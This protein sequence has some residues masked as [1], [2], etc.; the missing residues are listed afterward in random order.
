MQTKIPSPSFYQDPLAECLRTVLAFYSIHVDIEGVLT[1]IPRNAGPMKPDDILEVARK[2]SL[3]GESLAD[4]GQNWDELDIPAI[5]FLKDGSCCVVFPQKTHPGKVYDPTTGFKVSSWAEIQPHIL[6]KVILIHPA[7]AETGADLRHMWNLRAVDWFWTPILSFWKN[8]AEIILCSIFINLIV[9]A[10]PLFTMNV[11]DRVVPNFAEATLFVLAS[12]IV[13][14]TIFDF[15]LKVIRSYILETVAARVGGKFDFDF[16]ERLLLIRAQDM[17]LSTGERFNL[18]KE[19]QGVRD[20]YAAKMA[21]AIVDLPF[22]IVFMVVIFLISPPLFLVPLVGAILIFVINMFAQLP[23]K[24]TTKKFF[25]SMQKKSTVLVETLSGMQ[26]FKMFNA[27]GG[28]LARWKLIST[29]SADMARH[30][31]FVMGTS[32]ALSG[33]V[34]NLVYIFIVFFGVFQIHDNHLTV[35]GL[36]ACTTLAGRAVAPIMNI[37][38]VIARLRQSQ[39]V[40]KTIDSVFK[41]PYEGEDVLRNSAKGPFDGRIE[42]QNVTYSYPGQMRPAV[43]GASLVINPGEKVGLIGK[44]GAGKSTLAALMTGYM[45]GYDGEIFLDDFSLQAIAPTELRRSIAIV[46]QTSFFFAGTIREN[47]VMGREDASDEVLHR[48]V[49]LSGLD[50]T[51]RQTGQGLDTPVGENGERL[52]GGQRQAIALARAFLRDPKIL[53]FDEPT[54]GMDQLLEQRVQQ[55]MQEFLKGRTFIMITH[56]T[57]LLPLVDRLVLIDGGKIAADGPRDIVIRKLSGK[58]QAGE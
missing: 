2:M 19:L 24:M 7:P 31:Q 39:D 28:R 42:L 32:A 36:I 49:H 11:Y 4:E 3:R 40:L 10:L 5:V 8:Y 51:L 45:H 21:P 20:F 22:C 1:E 18:F 38:G 54:T 50:L 27:T 53:I 23:I 15:V 9:I 47:I 14:A 55:S 37:A 13:I 34:A 29:E 48:A 44:T 33:M 12:G 25:A 16:L 58:D 17:T 52:S 35:G 6:G 30:S 43:S 41:L 26:T 56:R 46:P 57:S